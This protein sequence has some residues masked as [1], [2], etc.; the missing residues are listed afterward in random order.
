MAH[1]A[2]IDENNTV[3]RVLVTSNDSP[4]EGFSWLVSRLGG[5]WIK[6]SYNT[7]GGEHR[8]GGEPLRKNFAGVGYSYDPD[9]DAFIAPKPFQSWVLNED[10]CL[11][12]APS[13][14]PDDGKLY[15]WDE[16]AGAWVEVIEEEVT[17]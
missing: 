9:R 17:E 12:Q 3:V 8:K 11:W 4:D 2:E 1:W 5:T 14:R 7:S 13:P 16:E 15:D 10:T 6:T